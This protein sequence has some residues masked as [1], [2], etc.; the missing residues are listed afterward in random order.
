MATIITIIIGSAT[1]GVTEAYRLPTP[2]IIAPNRAVGENECT[3]FI[4]CHSILIYTVKKKRKEEILHQKYV[5][6]SGSNGCSL[7]KESTKSV[8]EEKL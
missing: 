8:D 3:V 5:V 2:L 1:E 7:T 6:I 4:V